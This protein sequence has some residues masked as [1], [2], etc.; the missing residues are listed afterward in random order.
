MSRPR[1]TADRRGRDR[2]LESAGMDASDADRPLELGAFLAL[3][4][5]LATAAAE[6]HA[7]GRGARHRI[8]EK[9]SPFNLVTEVDREAERLIVEGIVAARPDDEILAE[10]G[11][12]R[13]GT[14]GARWIVDPLDGTANYVYGYAAHAVSIG[15]EI[16][17]DP[18][19]GVVFDT[20][21]DVLYTGVAGG[22]ARA[23]GE[24]I[25]ASAKDDVSTAMLATGFSFDPALRARQASILA[26]LA[27]RIRDIRRSGAASID[28]CALASGS[29]DAYY[30]AALAPWD[31]AG[32]I[33]I[34]R[35]AG[36]TVLSADGSSGVG[37][38]GANAA[39][40]QALL[41]I[42]EAAGFSL[43][44]A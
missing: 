44:A 29:V 4:V 7:E 38:V 15:I 40:L 42:L 21:R 10:E 37:V 26:D 36:A 39:L 33:V 43:D 8:E 25:S 9:G 28:L 1:R 23:N 32:G 17:G 31:V 3:A 11:A 19:V 41:P 13:H 18:A 30:E 5:E 27:P 20:A 14:S 35:A 6:V 34:A 12:S 24:T 16:G 22:V 2:H